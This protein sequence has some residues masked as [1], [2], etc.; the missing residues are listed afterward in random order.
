MITTFLR[1]SVPASVH[2]EWVM[3]G[4]ADKLPLAQPMVLAF[5]VGAKQLFLK[6]VTPAAGLLVVFVLGP[7][8]G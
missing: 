8:D 5:P 2:H 3:N 4:S 7:G 6:A 1:D